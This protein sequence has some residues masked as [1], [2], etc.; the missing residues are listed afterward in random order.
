MREFGPQNRRVKPDR[1][2][3]GCEF[4]LFCFLLP[5]ENVPSELKINRSRVVGGE[6][7]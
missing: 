4:F 6:R 7:P 1:L 5:S 3:A 2:D